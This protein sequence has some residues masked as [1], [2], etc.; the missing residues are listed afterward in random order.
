MTAEE[1]KKI[2]EALI[3]LVDMG[4]YVVDTDGVGM[5]YNQIMA[6]MEQI[7]IDDVIGKPFAKAFHGVKLE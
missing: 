6:D 4:I 7:R 2:L 1:Y 5:F 3:N